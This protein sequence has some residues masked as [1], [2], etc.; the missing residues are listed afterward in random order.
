MHK[1][2]L[3]DQGCFCFIFFSLIYRT[4]ALRR[5]RIFQSV[6]AYSIA[7]FSEDQGGIVVRPNRCRNCA[8][9]YSRF[10]FLIPE[11]LYN[12]RLL[13]ASGHHQFF[14]L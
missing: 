6:S 7:Y 2:S 3:D 13:N 9:I 14:R 5:I 10:L 4:P 12:A 11:L 1:N 8:G